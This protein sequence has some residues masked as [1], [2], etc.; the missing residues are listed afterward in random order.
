MTPS[1]A[2]PWHSPVLHAGASG[3]GGNIK[4]GRCGETCGGRTDST[5]WIGWVGVVVAVLTLGSNY[6]P[7]KKFDTG[8]GIMIWHLL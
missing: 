7:V 8:D 6:V 4:L 3:A 1:S 5:Q 2:K